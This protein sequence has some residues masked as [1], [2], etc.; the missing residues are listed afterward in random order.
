MKK[1]GKHILR[2]ERTA[3]CIMAAALLLMAASSFISDTVVRLAVS[4]SVYLAAVAVAYIAFKKHV[5][6][7]ISR[8]EDEK[9]Q[10]ITQIEGFMQ[11]IMTLLKDRAD[12]IPVMSNQ[13][14]GVV[15]HTESAALDIGNR[16]MN[17]VERARAQ[18]GKASDAFGRF[19]DTHAGET[20]L[21]LSKKALS[22]VIE[23]L[24]GISSVSS[25]TL[26]D[27]EIIIEAVGS[28]KRI[29]SD[30]EYLADQTNLL[31]LN[32]AIEAARAGEHGRGFAVVA[33]EVRKLSDRSNTSA[34][35]IKKLIQKVEEDIRNVYE[36]TE[37]NTAESTGKS[38][39]AKVVVEDTLKKID[40][41]MNDAK[42]Q[43]DELTA[44]TETLALDI[45]SIVTSMQFQDITRQRIEHVMEPLRSMKTELDETVLKVG[46]MYKEIHLW[47]EGDGDSAI[48]RLENLYTMESERNVMRDTLRQD[49]LPEDSASHDDCNVTIF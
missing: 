34:D 40:R 43:L 12:V 20:L 41:L 15:Q 42:S 8:H 30:I 7:L 39:E 25:Q 31:A 11:P 16:F 29:L 17:I 23:S 14:S 22:D 3:V 47:E 24:R 6:R 32:A 44:E 10:H 37:K 46:D 18:A 38:S 5:S 35:E 2:A 26:S 4:V 21:D 1:R 19:A 49:A 13:L 48:I 28:I 45:S 27:M 36:K 9:K 33:D